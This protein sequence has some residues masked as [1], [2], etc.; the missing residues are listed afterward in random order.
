MVLFCQYGLPFFCTDGFVFVEDLL[1]Q[2]QLQG[3]SEADVVRVVET[4]DKQRFKLEVDERTKKLKVRAN[5]GHTVEVPHRTSVSV[6]TVYCVGFTVPVHTV[7]IS[8][9]SG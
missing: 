8:T 4:N 6:C 1:Q 3:Y 7:D 9:Y 2:E 5:Q